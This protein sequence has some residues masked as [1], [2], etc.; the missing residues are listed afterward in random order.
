M[1][2]LACVAKHVHTQLMRSKAIMSL[3][4]VG[5]TGPMLPIFIGMYVPE[6]VEVATVAR[7]ATWP[8]LFVGLGNFVFLP[9]ALACGRRFAFLIAAA[10][11]LIATIVCATSNNFTTNFTGTLFQALGAGI[12]ESLLPL[13]IT[14]VTF[15]HERGKYFGIYVRCF[16]VTFA[17]F[18]DPSQWTTQSMLS[19]VLNIASTFEAERLSWRWYYGIYAIAVGIGLILAF[20]CCPETRFARPPAS[21]NGQVH[22][23]DEYGE[24]RVVSGEEAA[25]YSS[26]AATDVDMTP[27]TYGET[28]KVWNGVP[29]GGW[30]LA[31]KS[32]ISMAR[33]LTSP[34][35]LWAVIYTGMVLAVSI[36]LALSTLS[37]RLYIPR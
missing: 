30:K 12:T 6:G 14:D 22:V 19:S 23:T 25:A 7:F 20:F 10:M 24:Q 36:A 1:S 31:G 27:L 37:G 16:H 5:A 35:L 26:Y 3:S 21:F 33:C 34:G 17:R 28:L 15:V 11:C 2:G 9:L 4:L 32:Y 8:S 18:A 29:K 13:I